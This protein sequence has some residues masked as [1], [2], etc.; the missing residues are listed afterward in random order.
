MSVDG[1]SPF[2]MIINT[3]VCS[4]SAHG[5]QYHSLQA[6]VD[7]ADISRATMVL[8]VDKTYYLKPAESFQPI[9]PNFLTHVWY[10]TIPIIPVAALCF[11][12][13]PRTSRFT[14]DSNLCPRYSNSIGVRMSLTIFYEATVYIKI[15]SLI[16]SAR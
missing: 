13:L 8:L 6:S 11:Y 4:P 10:D 5:H 16:S 3:D 14:Y 9:N 12:I 2:R 15:S 1:P 7:V